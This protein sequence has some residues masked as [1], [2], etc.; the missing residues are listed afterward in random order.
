[1]ISTSLQHRLLAIAN[2]VSPGIAEAGA[3]AHLHLETTTAPVDLVDYRPAAATLCFVLEGRRSVRR[4]G[5]L[6]IFQAG[7]LVLL[8]PRFALHLR[9]EPN[10]ESG[11]FRAV[12][13]A[14]SAPFVERFLEEHSDD[15]SRMPG[16]ASLRLRLDGNL[17]ESLAAALEALMEPER[18]G[19]RLTARLLT[20]V[21]LRLRA[22]NRLHDLAAGTDDL[23]TQVRELVWLNPAEHWTAE[24]MAP[25]IGVAPEII[26][27]ALGGPDGFEA[28]IEDERLGRAERLVEEG[29]A[30][31]ADAAYACG[32]GS[33]E[34]FA[35]RLRERRTEGLAK[36]A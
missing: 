5:R 26:E 31:L 7:Q 9:D 1:M 33:P 29:G 2:Q 36:L 34:F 15:R 28:V 25:Q 13:L 24:R 30:S 3:F 19:S 17:A 14:F 21:L 16:D 4:A 35:A 10:E 22:Q 8:P 18:H 6:E 11:R 20:D 32:Y 12:E 27:A 23:E